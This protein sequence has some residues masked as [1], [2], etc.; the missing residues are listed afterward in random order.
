MPASSL[1]RE[2]CSST[3]VTVAGI[4][5][6][7]ERTNTFPAAQTNQTRADGTVALVIQRSASFARKPQAVAEVGGHPRQRVR[8]RTRGHCLVWLLVVRGQTWSSRHRPT[9]AINSPLQR[10]VFFRCHGPS[11]ASSV[12]GMDSSASECS[13]RQRQESATAE[14]YA[15]RVKRVSSGG[16]TGCSG[17]P[18]S[19]AWRSCRAGAWF[20]GA[21]G[22]HA[23]LLPPSTASTPCGTTRIP[24]AVHLAEMARLRAAPV[25][26]GSMG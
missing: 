16:H 2:S 14:G 6:P 24:M 20:V 13:L 25:P 7:C 4:W 26:G 1:G 19:E 8:L 9:A 23:P 10:S 5:A 3:S 15:P 12:V 17:S 11:H 22:Q 21:A 18:A